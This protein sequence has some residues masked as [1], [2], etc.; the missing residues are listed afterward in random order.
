MR[1]ALLLLL[2]CTSE[3]AAPPAP[4]V[5]PDLDHGQQHPPLPA[6]NPVWSWDAGGFVPDFGWYGEHSWA[7][8]RMR[9]AGHMAM[10][11][12]DL[13]RVQATGGDLAAAASTLTELSR[14]L[15]AIEVGDST[16]A[17]EIAEILRADA[18]RDAALLTA[19]AGGDPLPTAGTGL[20]SLRARYLALARPPDPATAAALE[21][22]LRPFLEP[23]TDLD[24]DAFADFDDR[25]RLRV[26]LFAA[27][28]DSLDPIGLGERWGYWEAPEIARQ[29]RLIGAATA[30]LTGTDPSEWLAGLEGEVPDLTE[31]DPLWRPS[32]LARALR[33]PDQRPDFTVE[34]LGALPTGDSLIDVGAEPGPRAIGTLEKWGL[35][36]PTHRS[37]LEAEEA[38]LETLLATHP[39]LLPAAVAA[40]AAQLDRGGHGSRFYNIK[41]LRNEAVR[42]LA[43]AGH[44]ALAQEVLLQNQPLHNQDWACPNRQG[45]LEAIEGRLQAEAGDLPGAQAT[46]RQALQTARAFLAQVDAS[47][48]AGP[49]RGP[50]VRPPPM[51]PGLLPPR[52]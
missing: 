32:T 52:R 13:A 7:D 26:R 36:D 6:D 47:E 51:Q 3:P 20:A 25:H 39:E 24:L 41:Q 35:T 2:A 50:G 10:A 1:F 31:V 15:G 19:L 12:R 28:G 46:L 14:E 23:R 16:V 4:L 11:A 22:E 17:G 8:V 5:G 30:T 27:W 18:A 9:V 48:A 33:S 34:G 43:R 49:G 44:P 38:Q 21:A 45:I 42:Q 37:W 40:G 29:A